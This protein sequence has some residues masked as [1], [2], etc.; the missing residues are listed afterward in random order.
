[1]TGR[2]GRRATSR[3]A[4]VVSMVA[5]LVLVM[6]ACSDG[7]EGTVESESA[8]PVSG[9]ESEVAPS[10]GENSGTADPASPSLDDPTS[11]VPARGSSTPTSVGPSTTPAPVDASLP[12]FDRLFPDPEPL[13][14]AVLIDDT[15]YDLTTDPATEVWTSPDVILSETSI[16]TIV[17]EGVMALVAESGVPEAENG[18]PA[19]PTGTLVL[20][21]V[22]L[23]DEAADDPTASSR[24]ELA[25]EVSSFVVGPAG[26]TFAWTE[27]EPL[28]DSSSVATKLVMAEFPYGRITSSFV[29]E[30]LQSGPIR[31]TGR[32]EIVGI[33]G[34][35][36]LIRAGDPSGVVGLIIWVPDLETTYRV[37]NYDPGM[38][39][40]T[41]ANRLVLRQAET[42][43]GVVVEV[44]ADGPANPVDGAEARPDLPCNA[45]SAATISHE[46]TAVAGAGT[47]G[48]SA[49][50]GDPMVVVGP[51]IVEPPEGS[52][53][54][55][56]GQD[57]GAER[58]PY[59]R[60]RVEGVP[61]AYWQP[62]TTRWLDEGN[63]VVLASSHNGQP[64]TAEFFAGNPDSVIDR[65]TREQWRSHW[66]LY[67]CD[68]EAGAC[69]LAQSIG[70]QPT[71][72]AQ[73]ALVPV[74]IR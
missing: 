47:T 67:T 14:I 39:G 61:G 37:M 26:R 16:P 10:P 35:N 51:A 28:D 65:R 57:E 52:E 71:T 32:A 34:D 70:F 62:R 13:P 12:E 33:A 64:L 69:R 45:S 24:I 18:R 63:L 25:R 73:L 20:D 4:G 8:A 1:M 2:R 43:C 53:E 29:F 3:W 74:R 66:G 46:G 49:I 60:L 9:I 23:G 31:T 56:S 21:R 6:P 36:V 7:I 48:D 58:E 15:V 22:A 50:D 55:G 19:E 17:N 41:W 68:L 72:V 59:R 38:V 5:V 27:P 42:G 11:Q 30:G 54:D 44:T 40:P